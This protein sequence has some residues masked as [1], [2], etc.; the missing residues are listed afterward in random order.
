LDETSRSGAYDRTEILSFSNF[1]SELFAQLVKISNKAKLSKK[2]RI[3][4]SNFN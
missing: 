2:I 3:L 1:S 4:I